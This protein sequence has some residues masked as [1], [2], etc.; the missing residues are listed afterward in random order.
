[1]KR[2]RTRLRTQTIALV[3]WAAGAA[4]LA[5]ALY[6]SLAAALLA[7]LDGVV[8]VVT[9]RTSLRGGLLTALAAVVPF[10]FADVSLCALAGEREFGAP[11]V[12]GLG[13]LG[14]SAV[15]ADT[16]SAAIARLSGEPPRK[17]DADDPSTGERP[18]LSERDAGLRR[19][20]W[21][22]ARSSGYRREVALALIGVDVPR[23]RD[24]ARTRLTLMAALDELVLSSVTRFDVVCEYGPC[25]RLMVLPEESAA[26]LSEAAARICAAATERLGWHVR[27]ALA[28]FPAHG[29]TLRALLGE[30]EIDLAA[31]RA[32]DI[33]VR[34]CSAGPAPPEPVEAAALDGRPARA[35]LLITPGKVVE[36]Q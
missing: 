13:L 27:M 34:V 14:A 2:P 9:L 4:A 3:A 15:I 11:M 12:L 36:N 33:A 30:L 31:C 26:S 6:P 16:A 5:T 17:L 32:D 22:L 18:A 35:G 25:E 1:V 7:F 8:M 20:E 10:A 21:E 29:R 23:G 28:G 19:A 24:E